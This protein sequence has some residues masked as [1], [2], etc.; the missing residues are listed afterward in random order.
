MRS[1]PS[2]CFH[3]DALYLLVHIQIF[4]WVLTEAY[5]ATFYRRVDFAQGLL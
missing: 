5:V 3:T 2:L 4:P 1:N